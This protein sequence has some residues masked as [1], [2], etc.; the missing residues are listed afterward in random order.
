MAI[1]RNAQPPINKNGLISTD[2]KQSGR[3]L[4][5][6]SSLGPWM[7]VGPMAWFSPVES[8]VRGCFPHDGF[9]IEDSMGA[10][11]RQ[12]FL[13]AWKKQIAMLGATF[14]EDL[15]KAES[16]GPPAHVHQ[17]VRTLSPDWKEMNP[18]NNPNEY[19]SRFIPSLASVM[20]AGRYFWLWLRESKTWA[21]GPS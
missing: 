15:D 3:V 2:T 17:K 6:P 9:V 18:A 5:W 4:R 12:R 8:G 21:E 7:P 20:L 11:W 13:V 14:R 19:G 16:L 1:R 10:D